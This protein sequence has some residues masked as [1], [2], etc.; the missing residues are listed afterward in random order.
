MLQDAISLLAKDGCAKLTPGVD[1]QAPKVSSRNVHSFQHE[2][3]KSN[4]VVKECCR[5]MI[6][7]RMACNDK[8]RYR[9]VLKNGIPRKALIAMAIYKESRIDYLPWHHPWP[10]VKF[11]A[12][13]HPTIQPRGG[14]P[15]VPC[16]GPVRTQKKGTFFAAGMG[17]TWPE[18]LEFFTCCCCQME[19]MSQKW[20]GNDHLLEGR[21]IALFLDTKVFTGGTLQG[22]TRKHVFFVFF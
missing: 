22:F 4:Y 1:C 15:C 9:P 20:Y 16:A 5:D 6:G 21:N 10:A 8:W 18:R 3:W 14:F 12:C 13:A 7:E 19:G 17:V 11:N 2:C